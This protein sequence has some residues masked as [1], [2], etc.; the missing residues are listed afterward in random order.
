MVFIERSKHRHKAKLAQVYHLA[1]RGYLQPF[2]GRVLML[3]LADDA[4][5]LETGAKW[6]LS[7][8]PFGSRLHGRIP[9]RERRAPVPVQ[10]LDWDL[11][12]Q[13]GARSRSAH[14][15]FLLDNPFAHHLLDG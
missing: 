12:Q 9:A 13:M 7:G 15:L 3:A 6:R 8:F 5:L 11:Q 10:H 14:L 1:T 4:V 2:D